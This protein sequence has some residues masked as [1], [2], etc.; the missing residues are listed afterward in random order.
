M[1]VHVSLDPRHCYYT[2]CSSTLLFNLLLINVT[3]PWGVRQ[4][5]RLVVTISHQR[6]WHLTQSS[7]WKWSTL[8][9]IIIIMHMIPLLEQT[10]QS[11][12]PVYLWDYWGYYS[13]WSIISSL[14]IK[15]IRFFIYC[16]TCCLIFW[17]HI[18]IIINNVMHLHIYRLSIFEQMVPDAWHCVYPHTWLNIVQTFNTW[19]FVQLRLV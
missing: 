6:G 5:L 10:M 3:F 14:K 9:N 18:K 7:Y 1:I 15:A 12:I 2:M 19:I 11:N 16:L 4:K 17:V 8:F 13:T